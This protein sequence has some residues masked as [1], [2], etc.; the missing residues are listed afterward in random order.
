VGREVLVQRA[1]RKLVAVLVYQKQEELVCELRSMIQRD[2]DVVKTR[3]QRLTSK[4]CP[5]GPRPTKGASVRCRRA[6]EE[7][8]RCAGP[9]R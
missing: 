8:Q 4:P 3:E 9:A 5:V 1:E 2:E 7:D 6:G